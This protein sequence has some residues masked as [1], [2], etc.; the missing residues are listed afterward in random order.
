MATKNFN[1]ELV[2]FEVKDIKDILAAK[3]LGLG[4]CRE[5]A[6]FFDEYVIYEDEDG[7]EVEREP[8][9]DEKMNRIMQAMK[10][11]EKI[12]ATC[13]IPR[14]TTL[15]KATNTILQSD[16]YVKQG[17]YIIHDNKIVRAQVVKIQ[18]VRSWSGANGQSVKT[19]TKYEVQYGE[20]GRVYNVVVGNDNIFESVEKLTEHLTSNIKG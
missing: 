20:F 11:G 6:D 12:Y 10:D 18:M 13:S 4:I 3:S 5:N 2:G 1:N 14:D 8:T 7:E 9:E 15:V 16:F 17:V 19:D